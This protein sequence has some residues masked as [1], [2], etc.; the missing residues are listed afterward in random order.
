MLR[1]ENIEKRIALQH[2]LSA[3]VAR[4]VLHT[5]KL[6]IVTIKSII[7]SVDCSFSH[8]LYEGI[9]IDH[10]NRPTSYLLSRPQLQVCHDVT[11]KINGPPWEKSIS[12]H[13][14]PKLVVEN[15]PPE[16]TNGLHFLHDYKLDEDGLPWHFFYRRSQWKDDFLNPSTITVECLI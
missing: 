2:H 12:E 16:N 10:Q 13:Q 14:L 4:N 1:K 5:D 3:T 11:I 6:R 15:L 8:T 7:S 9:V